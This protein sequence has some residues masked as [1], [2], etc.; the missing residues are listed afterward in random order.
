MPWKSQNLLFCGEVISEIHTSS[1]MQV[2]DRTDINFI[3]VKRAHFSYESKTLM[4]ST[5]NNVNF[6]NVLL[7]TFTREDPKSAITTST[8]KPRV[9]FAFLG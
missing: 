8:I 4:K 9:F 7:E 3:N 1:L 6:I 2:F 5:P